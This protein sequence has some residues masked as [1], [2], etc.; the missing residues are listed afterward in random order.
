MVSTIRFTNDDH[1]QCKQLNLITV[2]NGSLSGIEQNNGVSV[3]SVKDQAK[4][5]LETGNKDE[6]FWLCISG[7]SIKTDDTSANN[8]ATCCLQFGYPHSICGFS[9]TFNPNVFSANLNIRKTGTNV[10][11]T[12]SSA[13]SDLVVGKASNI[14]GPLL[15]V[16]ITNSANDIFPEIIVSDIIYRTV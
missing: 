3:L 15:N 1:Y 12:Y 6:D 2:P 10:E 11:A 16:Q 4:V 5:S 7:L 13:G 14:V 9:F 8:L